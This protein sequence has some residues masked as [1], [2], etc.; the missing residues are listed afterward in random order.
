MTEIILREA[1]VDYNEDTSFFIKLR[2]LYG[3]MFASLIYSSEAWGDLKKIENTLLTIETKALK[4]CL[5]GKSG[6]TNG[7]IHR[8]RQSR[9][10]IA[11]IK[12]MQYNFSR[13]INNTKH[14]DALMKEIWNLCLIQKGT[15]V[16]Q[17]YRNILENNSNINITERRLRLQISES[18]MVIRYRWIIGST[19][20]HMLYKSCLDDI[21]RTTITRWRLSSHKLRIETGQ[22]TI[23]KTNLENPICKVCSIIEDEEHSIYRCRAHNT[24]REKY[25]HRLNFEN[26]NLL[27]FFNPKSV[28]IA[29]YLA[30]FLKEIEKNMEDLDMT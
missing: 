29:N 10:F 7:D 21:K 30:K 22:Y 6:T 8:N 15:N 26:T 18:T 16:T 19:Y 13:K 27:N 11:V 12:D 9:Y 2:V 24:I 25:S 4:R 3:C 20:R 17:Y 1:W 23:P 14:D 28:V 5:G